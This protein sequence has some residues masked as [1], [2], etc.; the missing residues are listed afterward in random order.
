M[1]YT[2]HSENK[3]KKYEILCGLFKVK[4]V[5]IFLIKRCLM[6]Y[7]TYAFYSVLFIW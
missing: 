2:R 6:N 4:T 7:L 5:K 1:H 3:K